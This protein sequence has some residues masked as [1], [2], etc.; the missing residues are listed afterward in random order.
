[1]GK[2]GKYNQGGLWRHIWG[3]CGPLILF[4][5][6]LLWGHQP[7]RQ[8]QCQPQC[9]RLLWV[10]HQIFMPSQKCDRLIIMESQ[11]C[12]SWTVG[13]R[14]AA[15]PQSLQ[16]DLGSDAVFNCAWTG[17]PSLTIVWMKRGSG[18]VRILIYITKKRFTHC[19]ITFEI[20]FFLWLCQSKKNT[21]KGS[22]WMGDMTVQLSRSW[23][24]LRFSFSLSVPKA[25]FKHFPL[26]VPELKLDFN[27]WGEVPF[28]V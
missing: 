24:H 21:K 20:V 14:M 13:P 7:S 25:K 4:G 23:I 2:R 17:N 11:W 18:V 12:L 1:M 27:N 28:K 19:C 16:V 22:S 8:H 3:H 5:S 9:W 6:R 15:E 10:K 26:L